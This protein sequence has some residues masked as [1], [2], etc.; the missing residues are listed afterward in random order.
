MG[1]LND[2]LELSPH[3]IHMYLP[4]TLST[5]GAMPSTGSGEPRHTS[6]D[7]E[8]LIAVRNL[9]AFLLGQSLVATER[10]P[11]TF[12][13]FLRISD[14]LKSYQFSN[15]DGSTFGEV[16]NASFDSYV[17]ELRLADVRSSREKTIEGIVLGELC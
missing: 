17:D 8:L 2:S 11:T 16:A 1:A 4:L 15:L 6:Q 9:F 3:E 14:M 13:M 10:S 7:M 5:D 12:S